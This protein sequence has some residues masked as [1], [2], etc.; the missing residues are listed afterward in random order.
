MNVT[1]DLTIM[2]EANEL[3]E[4]LTS[5]RMDKP[6]LPMFTS[7]CPAW[8]RFMEYNYPELLPNISSCKSPQGM[9]GAILKSYY[10]QKNHIDFRMWIWPSR[11]ESS[12]L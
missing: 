12:P 2:E 4:R 1:A 10:C 6:P 8:I 11:P 5:N 7:C 9:F 3:I